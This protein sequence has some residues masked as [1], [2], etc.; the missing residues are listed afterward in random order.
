MKAA[1][2][3]SAELSDDQLLKVHARYLRLIWLFNKL[4]FE[5]EACTNV[6]VTR[7]VAGQY[8]NMRF[9]VQD[10]CVGDY[11]RKKVVHSS[12]IIPS[13]MQLDMTLT[14]FTAANEREE[15][16]EIDESHELNRLLS[17]QFLE[18]LIVKASNQT[19][20]PV[21]LK[22]LNFTLSQQIVGSLLRDIFSDQSFKLTKR[23]DNNHKQPEQASHQEMFGAEIR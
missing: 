4:K 10:D 15:A 12:L 7:L 16:M 13:F 9:T 6:N 14:F 3:Q 2:S 18:K 23:L 1:A 22:N 11:A 5:A 20:L 21:A 8:K 19:L 17:Q